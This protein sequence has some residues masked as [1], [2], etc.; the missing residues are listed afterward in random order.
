[1]S[2]EVITTASHR[3]DLSG[4][5]HDL[6]QELGEVKVCV[7]RLEGRLEQPLIVPG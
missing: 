2:A 6:R 1:M 7:A 4:E 3:R 5:I